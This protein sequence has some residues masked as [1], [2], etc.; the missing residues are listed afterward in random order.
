MSYSSPFNWENI[1]DYGAVVLGT[2]I[3]AL[4]MDLFLI[5]AQLAAGGVSGLAQIINYYTG[6]PIGLMTLAANAPLFALGWR[7]LGGPRF[8]LRTAVSIV[9]FSLTVD[10]L[11]PYLPPHGLTHDPVLNALYGGV[12]GGVGAGLIYRG[13]GTSGGTDILARILAQWRHIPL[14]QSYLF[15]DGLVI[16]LAGVT[17]G[18]EQAL[19]ALVALYVTGVAAEGVLS[20]PNVVRTAIIITNRPDEVVQRI[21]HGLNRGVT[22]LQGRG[23]YTGE[24]RAVLYCVVTRAE[25]EQLKNFVRQ[26]DPQ[27]FMVVGNAHEALGEG[28]RPW[29]DRTP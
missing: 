5:P 6:W 28:F 16:L 23:G 29:E 26:A 10:G 2:V 11:A 19:Y 20:G 13:R 8:A 15:A 1:R 22:L 4:A 25:V 7:H 12:L 24:T 3:L 9:I 27:A 14:A 21:L 18:W 17:F